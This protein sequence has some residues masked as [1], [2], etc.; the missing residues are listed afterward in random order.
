MLMALSLRYSVCLFCFVKN[1]LV[2]TTI[3]YL[4]QLFVRHIFTH[5]SL[6]LNGT[7]MVVDQQECYIEVAR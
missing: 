4:Y 5:C 7:S 3:V 1:P 6:Y 2:R